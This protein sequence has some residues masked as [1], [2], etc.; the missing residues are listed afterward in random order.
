MRE[1]PTLWPGADRIQWGCVLMHLLGETSLAHLHL[2]LGGLRSIEHS[3]QAMPFVSAIQTVRIILSDLVT[4][5]AVQNAV[6][7]YNESGR[8]RSF[9]IDT[10]PDQLVFSSIYKPQLD[11]AI[12]EAMEILRNGLPRER[13]VMK[14]A[15]PHQDL[16]VDLRPNRQLPIRLHGLPV[17]PPR[18]HDLTPHQ[19]QPLSVTLQEIRDLA[20]SLDEEDRVR[21]RPSRAWESRM[22][23][24][25]KAPTGRG[26][27]ETDILDLSNLKHLI[28]LPGAGKTTLLTLLC[29]LLGRRGLK[30]AVFFTSIEVAREYL[31]V[32]RC[33]AV[34]VALLVGRSS[35]THR[36]HANR[37]AELIA[38]EGNGGFGHS[39]EGVDLLGT[40][41]PLP[42]F[43]SE[44]PSVEVWKAGDAPCEELHEAGS[45]VSLLCPAWQLCG[46]VKNHRDLVDANV[47]LGHVISSDTQVPAHT[48]VERLRYFELI[49]DTF[50]LVIFDECDETQK[51]LDDHGALTL[52]LSGDDDSLHTMLQEL[53]GH[54]TS[55]RVIMSDG[56]MRYL[57]QAN[58]FGRHLLRF[59]GEVARLDR[60]GLRSLV[61][62]YAD[63][64]LTSSFLIY[65]A[66]QS[67]GVDSE[68]SSSR[69]SA[70]SDLWERALY[71]AYFFRAENN[72][73]W[74][75]AATYAS[76]LGM[77]EAEANA[78]WRSMNQQFKRYLALEHESD[79]APVFD[80][81]TSEFTR[82]IGAPADVPIGPH[83]RLLVVV[84]C[85]VASY[86]RLA[87]SARPLALRGEI[88]SKL[89]FGRASEELRT[90]VPRSI[91]GTYSGVRYRRGI[92]GRGFAFDYLVMDST[93]R[94]LP[95]RLYERGSANVLLT[96]ATS[97]LPP[98]P[99]YHV[100]RR[101]DYVIMPTDPNGGAVRLYVNPKFHPVTREPLRFSGGGMERDQNLLSMVS[102]LA[103]PEAGGPSELQRAIAATVTNCGRHRK[104][105][106]VVNSYAQVRLVVEQIRLVNQTLYEHTR[107]VLDV[108][109]K[110]MAGT[111]SCY[112][113]KGAVEAL[114]S[115]D[116]IQLL[117]FPMGALGRGVN[118]VFRTTDADNGCAAIGN[119][120]FLTR[121]H[122]AAGD[123][124][125]MVGLLARSTYDMDRAS[126][127]HLSLT[128]AQQHYLVRRLEVY[129]S[130]ANLLARPMSASMLPEPVLLDFAAN[131]IVPILQTIG[132]GMRNRMPVNAYFVDAA[133]APRSAQ[134]QADNRRSSVLVLMRE[135]LSDLV[136]DTDL[137]LRDIHTELYGMF[138]EAFEDINNLIVGP[139]G[140]DDFDESFDP[141]MIT[142]AAD[143]EEMIAA[144]DDEVYGIDDTDGDEEFIEDDE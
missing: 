81:I 49:A 66:I 62:R 73:S 6:Y 64:L 55:N 16:V 39:R 140:D 14:L 70:L 11:P 37:M 143:F 137:D 99:A 100:A 42:A 67:A 9:T 87:R 132:R 128:E 63:K 127:D 116:N 65:E 133:W 108:V 113:L 17:I 118:I 76:D 101:P 114:G 30:V 115:D 35:D 92:E 68:V 111:P 93:P 3:R 57:L 58:E 89:V 102:A 18:Q 83:I 19:R 29:V 8:E 12:T 1:L 21:G 44:W 96:S 136:H 79:A 23:F 38:G 103:A 95:Y 2:V 107:G 59:L 54:L 85:T 72:D 117:V 45:Q 69:R 15:D 121:P 104:V 112:V 124:S 90:L 22:R 135:I 52:G 119:I 5:H 7:E 122:P 139:I 106:L 123:L 20:R 75:K 120:Y 60:Q 94:L 48:S 130:V 27:A 31:E 142:T 53:T 126:F 86:Q 43:A 144:N 24:D 26:L 50:D 131:Q 25:L 33:Y 138:Y 13:H 56:L 141:G 47:W 129:R 4:R 34:P 80:A 10:R 110:Q 61:D 28:G 105:A 97:W 77:T 84:G 78:S 82:L 74:P 91:L 98:S 71:R 40:S 51:V 109:P 41:C 46:R 36:T 32:L 88:P 134:E 125:L